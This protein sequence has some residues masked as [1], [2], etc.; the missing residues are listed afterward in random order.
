MSER[1][2]NT[3]VEKKPKRNKSQDITHLTGENLHNNCSESLQPELEREQ[4]AFVNTKF[5]NKDR[6]TEKCDEATQKNNKQFDII[7]HLP[8]EIIN[9]ILQELWQKQ[10][11]KLLDVSKAWRD[12]VSAYALVWRT[13]EIRGDED[14]SVQNIIQS[15]PYVCEHV[16][17]LSEVYGGLLSNA[18]YVQIAKGGFSKLHRLYLVCTYRVIRN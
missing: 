13:I 3:M 9:L 18:L 11:F 5:Y 2:A 8:Q 6:V 14:C 12:K 15:L 16:V 7:A 17:E 1:A 4:D 10:C